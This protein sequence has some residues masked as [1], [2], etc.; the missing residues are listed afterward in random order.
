M[1]LQIAVVSQSFQDEA[2]QSFPNVE[3]LELRTTDIVFDVR[4]SESIAIVPG[5]KR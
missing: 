3:S 1:V 2:V 4:D 5:P